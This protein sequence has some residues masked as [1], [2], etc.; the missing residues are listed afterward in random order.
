MGANRNEI[1]WRVAFLLG[2]VAAPLGYAVVAGVPATK[3][4]GNPGLL[5]T[6]GLLVG[7]GTRLGSGCTRTSPNSNKAKRLRAALEEI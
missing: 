2:L 7:F 5:A 4:T 6:A 1:G 3:V